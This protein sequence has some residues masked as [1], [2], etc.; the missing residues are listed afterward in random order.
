L[1]LQIR[2]FLFEPEIV[3]IQQ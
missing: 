1:G 3:M 2:S